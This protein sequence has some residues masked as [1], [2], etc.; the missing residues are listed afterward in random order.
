MDSAV[1][2][3]SPEQFRAALTARL[4]RK[5]RIRTPAVEAAFGAVPRHLFVPE[6]VPLDQA[7]ADE[8][9]AT[10]RGPDSRVTSSVSAPWLQAYMLEQAG[11]RPGS[12]VLE[13]GSGGY[14][15]AL[16]AEIVGPGGTW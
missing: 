14:Q 12:R 7:Y 15:A 4:V 3:T 2:S 5:N 10:K 11:L 8:I 16:I 6:D 9:V 13:I 1:Q